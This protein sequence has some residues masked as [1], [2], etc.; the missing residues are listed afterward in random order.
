MGWFRHRVMIYTRVIKTL[1][2]M[3]ILDY[4]ALSCCLLTAVEKHELIGITRGPWEQN[5]TVTFILLRLP[6]PKQSHTTIG[7]GELG[8]PSALP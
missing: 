7:T 1:I 4:A 2:C 8:I 6:R 3:A 5:P